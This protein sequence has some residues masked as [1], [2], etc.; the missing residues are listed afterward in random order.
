MSDQEKTLQALR[1]LANIMAASSRNEERETITKDD[2]QEG[3]DK[4]F[5]KMVHYIG[6]VYALAW[7]V[8]A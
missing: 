4:A 8:P 1:E 5:G 3:I 7:D 2:E 6:M